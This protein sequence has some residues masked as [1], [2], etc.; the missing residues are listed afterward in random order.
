MSLLA[1]NSIL[2]ELFETKQMP[3]GQG[4]SVSIH[5]NIPLSYAETLYQTVLRQQPKLAV[6]IGMAFGV[7]TLSILTALEQAGDGRLISIDPFQTKHWHGCGLKNVERAG[8]SHRH[9]MLEAFDYLTLPR[10]LAEKTTIDFAYIDGW[11]TF[12]YTLLDF[13]YIDKMLTVG[14]VIGFNDCAW[15]GVH[16]AIK[17]VR[18]H[19]KY[20]EIEVGL[21]R[22][23]S[24]RQGLWPLVRGI[25]SA[26]YRRWKQDRYFRKIE[27]WEPSWNFFK[28]F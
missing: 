23:I 1:R 16:K 11:H 18:T 28:D 15:A 10:L 13:W 2:K 4:N 26:R 19:R 7:A 27:H 22:T 6:E 17:F 9:Q 12:D 8:L 3:D 5:S 20:K 24:L 14:G 25:F 21:A